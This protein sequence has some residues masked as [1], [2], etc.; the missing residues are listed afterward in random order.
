MRG[1]ADGAK[2]HDAITF[3]S[4]RKAKGIEELR[5]GDFERVGAESQRVARP[6]SILS[7]PHL[8]PFCP[9]QTTSDLADITPRTRTPL[10]P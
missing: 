10:G 7:L 8:S 2:R 6:E 5:D 1:V 3:G 4:A 9:A